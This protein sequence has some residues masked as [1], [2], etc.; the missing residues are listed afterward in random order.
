[1]NTVKCVSTKQGRSII[2]NKGRLI[3][4]RVLK[5]ADACWKQGKEKEAIDI[6]TMLMPFILP[7]LQSVDMTMDSQVSI[8]IA[9]IKGYY[10]Q[11]ISSR[12]EFMQ[13]GEGPAPAETTIS[14]NILQPI[15][16]VPAADPKVSS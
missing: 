15:E 16:D 10:E 11:I 9:H 8:D 3:A 5:Y 12:N 13:L 6:Y 7:K 4:T 1:M 14:D 2:Q